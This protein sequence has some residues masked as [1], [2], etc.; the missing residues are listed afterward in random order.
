MT[1]Q[2][3]QP[4][5][6]PWVLSSPALGLFAVMLL[7]PLLLTA[8]LSLHVFDGVGAIGSDYSLANYVE[9]L[10]DPYYYEI[11]LRTLG[12]ALGTTLLCLIF[13]VPETIILSRMRSPWRACS[14]SSF[15]RRCWSRWWSAHWA[16]PF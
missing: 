16:G 5:L 2:A 12:L 9:I 7:A 1:T 6:T 3:R 10:T 13:G 4:W 14:W 11:F 15:W 8:I